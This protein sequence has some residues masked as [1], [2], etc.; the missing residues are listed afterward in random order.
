[1]LKVVNRGQFDSQCAAW[2]GAVRAGAER[3]VVKMMKDAQKHATQISPVYSGDFASNWNVSYGQPDTTFISSQ[4]DYMRVDSSL[5]AH[6]LTSSAGVGLGNFNM[7]GFKLGQTAYLTNAAEHDEPYA[8]KIE[9]GQ[10]NFR[11]VNQGKDRVAGKTFTHLEINYKTI[12][13][14]HMA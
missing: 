12:T 5:N 8:W 11:P 4:G 3:A 2:L 9:K 14:G 10:I 7:S 6:P 1:M 13:R